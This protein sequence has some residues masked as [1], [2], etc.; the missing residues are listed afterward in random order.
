VAGMASL[1]ETETGGWRTL[2]GSALR[3]SGLR[4]R[5]RVANLLSRY[6]GGAEVRYTD[7]CGFDRVADLSDQMEARVFLG[8]GGLPAV[9]VGC[10]GPGDWVIDVGA[11]IGGT[12]G[13]MCRAVGPHGCV[14]ALEPVPRNLERLRQLQS[15][16]AISQL[17]VYPVAAS[18]ASGSAVLSLAAEGFSGHASFHNSAIRSGVLEVRTESIDHLVESAPPGRRLRFIK[19]DVEGHEMEVLEGARRTLAEHRPLVCC[20]VNAPILRDRGASPSDL[21]DAFWALGYQPL[22]PLTGAHEVDDVLLFPRDVG[23]VT[24]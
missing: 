5:R 2:A 3:S 11:N 22:Y 12:T 8:L 20:E 14:W 7:H 1:T 15:T 17:T 10:F 4:G 18:S 23:A 6:P 13:E 21:L 24:L 16:N 9:A 19:I